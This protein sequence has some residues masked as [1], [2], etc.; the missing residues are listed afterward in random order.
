VAKIHQKISDI[1]RD[2]LHKLSTR[3]VRENQTIVEQDVFG[4]RRRSGFL[5]A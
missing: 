3:L 4:V 1:R 2:D 5:A